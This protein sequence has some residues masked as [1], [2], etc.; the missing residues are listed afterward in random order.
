MWTM[1]MQRGE[2]M[3]ELTVS[4]HAEEHEEL[5]STDE[6]E[7]DWTKLAEPQ[8]NQYD[9]D[10]VLRLARST[11][12]RD[13]P[14]P[15]VRTPAGDSPTVFDGAVAV[16]HVYKGVSEAQLLADNYLDAPVDH[17]NVR[18]A[19][20]YV[21]RWPLAFAQCQRLLEAIHP[22]IDPRIPFASNEIYRGSSCHSYERFFGTM[23]STIHCPLGLAEAIVHELAHQK[24]R[25]LGVSFEYAT[26]IVGNDPAARYSSPIV[27]DRLRP[28]SAVLQGEYAY[29]Y[30]TNLGVHALRAECDPERRRVLAGVLARNRARIEEGY[31]TIR[32]H[33]VPG[34][35]GDE[36]MRGFLSWTEKTI[37]AAKDALS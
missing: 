9:T 20:E 22:G 18:V 27:K 6:A 25:T 13:R 8:E 1:P 32:E 28:M 29:L 31:S 5:G 15:Y 17:P 26:K 4:T 12:S 10:V 30:V 16:R 19:A 11:V 37:A 36:F 35:H 3:R 21:R 7:I 23:W 33:F 24:L 34:E 14:D 2:K